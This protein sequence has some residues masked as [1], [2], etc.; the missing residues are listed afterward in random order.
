MITNKG[1]TDSDTYGNYASGPRSENKNSNSGANYQRKRGVYDSSTNRNSEIAQLS[2]SSNMAWLQNVAAERIVGSYSCG[3]PGPLILAVAGIHGNEPSGV[4]AIRAFLEMLKSQAPLIAGTFLGL[5]GNLR[6]CSRKQRYVDA[7]LNRCFL[8]EL[9]NAK[10]ADGIGAEAQELAEL[11]YILAQLGN[12]YED[13]CFIDC[14]TTS[15][16]TTPYISINVHTESLQLANRFPLNNVIGLQE[17]IPGCFAEYC[18]KLNYRGFTF[19]AG[20]HLSAAAFINQIAML[21]LTLVY[22]GALRK[23][24]LKNFQHYEQI[25]AVD[26]LTRKRTYRLL[27]HYRIEDGEEF[28]MKSGFENFDYVRQDTLLATNRYGD[29]NASSDGYLLMPL[30]QEHGDDG[31]F[32]LEEENEV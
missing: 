26:S 2:N 29:V 4:K 15:A 11:T 10:S 8:P 1:E 19:E 31:F 9:I 3:L 5:V 14:H 21:W 6:A 30:Y 22:S 7:D 32:L 25:L 24:D 16:L 17:A 20:Q 18:N 13:I 28:R 27:V 12:Q 23:Q